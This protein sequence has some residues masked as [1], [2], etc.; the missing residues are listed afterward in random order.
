VEIAALFGMMAYFLIANL[1]WRRQRRKL[2][3]KV[4]ELR[5][6]MQADG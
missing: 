1:L 4:H 6:K 3:H 5:H 2:Q